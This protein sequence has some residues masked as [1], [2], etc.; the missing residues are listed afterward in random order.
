MSEPGTCPYKSKDSWPIICKQGKSST[1]SPARTRSVPE[2]ALVSSSPPCDGASSRPGGKE[3]EMERT[4]RKKKRLL[5]EARRLL[6]SNGQAQVT[7]T[8]HATSLEGKPATR[9]NRSCA[10]LKAVPTDKTVGRN[11]TIQPLIT[12][13]G[14][15]ILFCSRRKSP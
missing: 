14:H 10:S 2:A 9:G 15:A 8:G 12:I 3:C 11:L 6:R 1:H 13:A 5:A 4:E 7:C